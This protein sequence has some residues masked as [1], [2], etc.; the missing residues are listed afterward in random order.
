[1]L[2]PSGVRKD[3][4]TRFSGSG[5]GDFGTAVAAFNFERTNAFS[6]YVWVRWTASGAQ[7][8]IGRVGG[9]ASNTGWSL[10][11]QGTALRF[12]HKSSGTS[13]LVVATTATGWNDGKW[14]AV[15]VTYDGSSTPGGCHIYVD[16]TDQPLTTVES[17]LTTST[18][19]GF[20]MTM[21]QDV[22]QTAFE[23]TG[24]CAGLAVF[25]GVLGSTDRAT[26]YNG[27]RPPSKTAVLA[28]SGLLGFW[29]MGNGATYPT[30]P[31][32]TGANPCTLTALSAAALSTY[33]PPY[34]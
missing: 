19:G 4:C 21:A 17:T 6:F 24:D 34:K 11:A 26:L 29:R 9:S 12:S 2:A 27:R 33:A 23:Y 32:E 13:R 8:I 30:I 20:Q 18:Q 3:R 1:M 28:I 7:H 16:G 14:H 31:D 25:S 22:N 10:Y 15:L 5:Y